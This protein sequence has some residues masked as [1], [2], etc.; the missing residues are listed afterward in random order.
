MEPLAP[1][2]RRIGTIMRRM[3]GA[4]VAKATDAEIVRNSGAGAPEVVARILMGTRP[5]GVTSVD[6]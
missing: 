6:R 5:R 1:G 4:S 3:P 2:M